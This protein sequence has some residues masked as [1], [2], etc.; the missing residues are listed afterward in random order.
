MSSSK[1][2]TSAT[3]VKRDQPNRMFHI[4]LEGGSVQRYPY[5][6]LRDNCR[7]TECYDPKPKWRLGAL[8]NT[9]DPDI[10]PVSE[11][12]I[13]SGKTFEV[14]W[15]EQ[16]TSRFSIEWLAKM[17]FSE[18]H[19]DPIDASRHPKKLW[20]A[21]EL[22]DNVPTFLFN[23][24]LTDDQTALDWLKAILNYGLAVI[25]EAPQEPKT[26][27]KLGNRVGFMKKTFLG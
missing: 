2:I 22:Q 9:L 14:K 12:L 26:I 15:P 10:E 19:P 27:I 18:S 3:S 4:E 25:K 1:I 11:S 23:D 7:C 20:G 8:I 21:A 17:K 16:H 24:I 13:D 5:V 6:W